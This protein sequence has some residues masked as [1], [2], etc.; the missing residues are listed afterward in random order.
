MGNKEIEG[1]SLNSVI[2]RVAWHAVIYFIW[3][4]RNNRLHK[5]KVEGVMHILEE[6]KEVVR[7]RLLGLKK[8]KVNSVNF[9]LYKSWQL[10]QTIFV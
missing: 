9:S 6:I 3:Q 1:K 8:V 4:E 5:N 10:S 7:I 2:L